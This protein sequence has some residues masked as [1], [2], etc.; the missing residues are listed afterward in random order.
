MTA[1]T[2][3]IG[4]LCGAATIIGLALLAGSAFDPEPSEFEFWG[5]DHADRS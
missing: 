3:L 2:F 1:A 5:G 4:F